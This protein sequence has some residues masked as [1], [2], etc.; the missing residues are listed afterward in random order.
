MT[1]KSRLIW[2]AIL[3]WAVVALVASVSAIIA[4]DDLQAVELRHEVR[5]ALSAVP[6]ADAIGTL[7]YVEGQWRALSRMT[8]WH[9]VTAFILVAA[10]VWGIARSGKS[11]SAVV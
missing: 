11:R 7:E 1:L 5:H 4:D 9:A 2:L 8:L 6:S 3:V 10:S